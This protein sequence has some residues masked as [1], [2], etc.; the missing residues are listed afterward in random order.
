MDIQLLAL[1]LDG[2][3]LNDRN[4]VSPANAKAVQQARAQGVKVAICTGRVQCEAEYAAV[5]LGGCDYM[6][7][8]NG[9]CVYDVVNRKHLFINI[10]PYSLCQKIID[11]LDSF[12]IFYQIY[13]DDAVCC[14]AHLFDNFFKVPMNKE[15]LHMFSDTQVLLENPRED[16]INKKLDV[17]K[18]FVPNFDQDLVAQVRRKVSTIPGVE[19]LYSSPYAI[20][21][22]QEGMDKLNGLTRLTNQLGITFDQVMTVGDSEN[23]FKVIKAAKY[24]VAMEN[25]DDYIKKAAYYVTASHTEDGVARA[26]EKLILNA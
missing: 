17:I 11:A 6:V 20:E 4:Q 16:I 12:H 10:M 3:L 5:Q 7:T 2:T 8:C 25:A 22:L 21:V 14:P 1:D 24:G 15:Y 26:V 18:Y 9:A 13:V 23:D 19:V